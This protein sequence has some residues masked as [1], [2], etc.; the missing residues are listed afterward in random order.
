MSQKLA[1]NSKLLDEMEKG[2]V[3]K[4]KNFKLP[5]ID[6]LQKAPRATKKINEAEIDQKIDDL[7][8]KLQQFKIEGE[9]VRTYSGPLVTTFEFKPAPNVKVSKI[10]GSAR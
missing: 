7:M 10:L 6:F 2:A 5:K 1:E 9:V 3:T 8:M 4:P